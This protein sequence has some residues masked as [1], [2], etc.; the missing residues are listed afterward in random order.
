MLLNDQS[1]RDRAQS[2]AATLSPEPKWPPQTPAQR[3]AT[4]SERSEM[5][6]ALSVLVFWAFG[7]GIVLGI[8]AIAAGVFAIGQRAPERG[9]SIPVD[10]LVGLAVGTLGLIFSAAFFGMVRPYL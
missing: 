9:K 6:G 2:F 5:L 8:G 3:V 10:A 1:I 4:W 7:L